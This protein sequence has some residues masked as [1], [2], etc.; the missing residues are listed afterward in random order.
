MQREN[1]VCVPG[2][3]FILMMRVKGEVCS[4]SA[5]PR[6]ETHVEITLGSSRETASGA[7]GPGKSGGHWDVP[8]CLHP[9]FQVSAPRGT[10]GGTCPP[11]RGG[12]NP[13]HRQML[14]AGGE[15]H[16]ANWVV[17]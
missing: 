12:L 16:A 1:G 4:A 3:C 14:S 7:S 2:F 8:S 6:D 17:L 11:C 13:T 5:E 15:T 9:A 10:K